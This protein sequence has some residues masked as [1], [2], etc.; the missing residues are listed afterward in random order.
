MKSNDGASSQ[1]AHS[2]FTASLP[3]APPPDTGKG[4]TKPYGHNKQGAVFRVGI[5]A[6]FLFAYVANQLLSVIGII[7]ACLSTR[8][9]VPPLRS[10]P[11][12]VL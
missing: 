6:S 1:P 5:C 4:L 12:V 3:C 11:P 10:K 9:P 7:I 2:R 8:E